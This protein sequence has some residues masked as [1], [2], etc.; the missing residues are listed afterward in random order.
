MAVTTFLDHVDVDHINARARQ[1]SFGAVLARL[2][3]TVLFTLGWLT[4][5]IFSVAWFVIAWMAVAVAEGWN[6]GRAEVKHS[7]RE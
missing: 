6:A 1:I 5:K 3:V 4:A 2:I 7:R